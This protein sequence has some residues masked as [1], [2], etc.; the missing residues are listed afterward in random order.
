MEQE[1]R[2]ASDDSGS[3]N[4][5]SSLNAN[6]PPGDNYMSQDESYSGNVHANDDNEEY[7]IDEQ[8]YA[9]SASQI[10]ADGDNERN[11]LDDDSDES[12]VDASYDGSASQ[13]VLVVLAGTMSTST[14]LSLTLTSAMMNISKSHWI[15]IGK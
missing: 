6:E 2:Y 14:M 9:E 7:D 10:N 11:T 1:T 3:E 15:G 12:D 8:S 13:G 5:S 4:G